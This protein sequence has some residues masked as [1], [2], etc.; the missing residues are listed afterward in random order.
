MTGKAIDFAHF[1]W[2]FSETSMQSE[3]NSTT[4]KSGRLYEMG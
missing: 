2:F 1:Q 4:E 3:R